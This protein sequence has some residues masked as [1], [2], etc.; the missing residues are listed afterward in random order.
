MT[1][2]TWTAAEP[3]VTIALLQAAVAEHER[4]TERL[5]EAYR[6]AQAACGHPNVSEA[7][8]RDGWQPARVCEDCGLE[9]HHGPGG[10]HVLT[11]SDVKRLDDPAELWRLRPV[12]GRTLVSW[13]HG[14]AFYEGHP[15]VYERGGAQ[16][17]EGRCCL[18]HTLSYAGAVLDE[19]AAATGRTRGAMTSGDLAAAIARYEAAHPPTVIDGPR[20][21][22]AR[23][24]EAAR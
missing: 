10:F 19:F 22:H 14:N 18:Q 21:R 5:R 15:V 24:R 13:C 6:A 12:V 4:V 23:V 8:V 9:E 20:S 2:R 7:I 16:Q 17:V 11:G 1:A 3:D